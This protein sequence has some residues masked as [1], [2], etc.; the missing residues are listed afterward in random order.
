MRIKTQ[1]GAV[2]VVGLILLAVLSLVAVVAMQSTT[3]EQRMSTN[4]AF[5]MR[6]MESSEAGRLALSKVIDRH[7][8]NRGWREQAG[9]AGTTDFPIPTGLTVQ[10]YGS[11][12]QPWEVKL[13][14][15]DAPGTYPVID[16]S[17]A[18]P[19]VFD[20]GSTISN[21]FVVRTDVSFNQ[22][23]GARMHAGY[24]G[25]GV[26][27]AGSGSQ[28]MFEFRSVSADSAVR[29]ARSVTASEYRALVRN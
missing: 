2:L 26:G 12:V 21:I 15:I 20:D 22:G 10:A 27:A 29:G 6:T 28:V 5:K 23:S 3:L 9:A 17:A 19:V 11:V 4:A 18:P 8:F 24:L 13:Y 1:D 16:Y 14:E 7:I 25:L